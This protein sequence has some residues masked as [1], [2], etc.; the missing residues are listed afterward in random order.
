MREQIA[1]KAYANA[2]YRLGKD[3]N[4]NVAAELVKFNEV[5]N[6]S[7]DLENLLFMDVFTV[8]EKV[9]VIEEV[10]R[11]LSMSE[12][13]TKFVKFL[14]FEKRI[15][16]FPVIFK[17]VVVLDD[18]ETGFLR[19]VLEV[20]KAQ[21]EASFTKLSEKIKSYLERELN[22]KIKLERRNNT[23]NMAGYRATVGDYQLDASLNRQLGRFKGS[24]FNA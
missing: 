1:A 3:K 8:E 19:G 13:V 7:N 23:N 20:S 24:I 12:L 22:K 5:V 9:S 21:E 6:G 11:R 10:S 14:I 16:L 17:D 18:E 15:G 2:I 4:V